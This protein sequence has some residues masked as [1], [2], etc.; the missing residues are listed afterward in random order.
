MGAK[1]PTA[2]KISPATSARST[3]RSPNRPKAVADTR[4]KAPAM[5]ARISPSRPNRTTRMTSW[6]RMGSAGARCR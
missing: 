1:K 4:K 3:T 5:S 6:T 2:L